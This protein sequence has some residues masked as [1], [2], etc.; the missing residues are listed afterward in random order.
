MKDEPFFLLIGISSLE[1]VRSSSNLAMVD[2]SSN[3]QL[4]ITWKEQFKFTYP[5]SYTEKLQNE[6]FTIQVYAGKYEK[7]NSAIF[8]GDLEVDFYSLC[9]GPQNNTFELFHS[10]FCAELHCRILSI[11]LSETLFEPEFLIING[12]DCSNVYCEYKLNNNPNSLQKSEKF[13]ISKV[14]EEPTYS[15]ND[16]KPFSDY[17]TISDFA[18]T[19][20]F[21]ILNLKE[22]DTKRNLATFNFP[23]VQTYR[24]R[25]ETQLANLFSESAES[26]FVLIIQ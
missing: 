17:F 14:E 9:V 25:D 22:N 19:N 15:T 23:F 5:I 7:I 12:I 24:N 8:I 2:S 6:Y 13:E 3:S 18:H 20:H 4:T 21:I 26:I 10:E 1:L 11:Q 16:L